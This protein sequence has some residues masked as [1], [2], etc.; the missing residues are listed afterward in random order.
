MVE[1]PRDCKKSPGGAAPPAPRSPPEGL[2]GCGLDHFKAPR[3]CCCLKASRGLLEKPLL[4]RRALE[5][6]WGAIAGKDLSGGH[7]GE[8]CTML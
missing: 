7:E 2:P 4:R 5:R 3:S 1:A 6:L 8:G